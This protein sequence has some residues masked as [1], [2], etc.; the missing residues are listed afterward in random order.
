MGFQWNQTGT[1]TWNLKAEEYCSKY[2]TDADNI[3]VSYELINPNPVYFSSPVAY[4][5]VNTEIVNSST[6]WQI[7]PMYFSHPQNLH[8][9]SD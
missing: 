8:S 6:L 9:V 5:L 3:Q 4:S 7:N 1:K 2:I